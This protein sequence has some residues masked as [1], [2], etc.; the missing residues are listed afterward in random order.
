[1]RYGPI[2]RA[3][4]IY[5]PLFPL[6]LHRSQYVEQKLSWIQYSKKAGWGLS[7]FGGKISWRR[8][9]TR[10]WLDRLPSL[11]PALE[12]SGAFGRILADD[13]FGPDLPYAH[14]GRHN[15]PD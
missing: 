15:F 11:Q 3:V 7:G 2:W 8:G 14:T 9:E 1:M 10:G 12:G 13:E 4:G 5:F 6:Q